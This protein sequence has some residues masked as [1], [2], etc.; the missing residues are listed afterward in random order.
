M[1]NREILSRRI[2]CFF[3]EPLRQSGADHQWGS[4]H[5]TPPPPSPLAK[6]VKHGER[7]RVMVLMWLL[8]IVVHLYQCATK[9]CDQAQTS[10]YR[11]LWIKL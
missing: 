9:R 6:V 2:D 1:C 4:T 7:A 3:R 8:H 11:G 10:L 5:T